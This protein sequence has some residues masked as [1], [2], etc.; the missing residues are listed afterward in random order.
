MGRDAE[1]LRDGEE[2]AVRVHIKTERLVLL[3]AGSRGAELHTVQDGDT[4]S[5]TSSLIFLPLIFFPFHSVWVTRNDFSPPISKPA[6]AEAESLA[7]SSSMA[8]SS[9]S[10]I[11]Y[12]LAASS[13]AAFLA[14]ACSF[15]TLANCFAKDSIVSQ[16]SVP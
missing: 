13:S 16:M 10:S 2:G 4:L 7:G 6:H 15:F 3:E 12:F 5:V 11:S 14:A 8:F 9:S 1:G